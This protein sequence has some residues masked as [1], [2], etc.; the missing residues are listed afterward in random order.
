[1]KTSPLIC[2]ALLLAGCAS[3]YDMSKFL[4]GTQYVQKP[5]PSLSPDKVRG[6]TASPKPLNSYE[7]DLENAWSEGYFAI[8]DIQFCGPAMPE[9]DARRVA[10][11]HGADYF[12]FFCA[13]YGTATGSRMV[14]VGYTTPSVVTSSS[15]GN[16]YASSPYGGGVNVTGYGTSTSVV[17]GATIYGRENYTYQN[18][19][20]CIFLLVSPTRKAELIKKGYLTAD[21]ASKKNHWVK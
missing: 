17:G 2:L 8:G 5:V 3:N 6:V 21:S 7:K 16:A 15:Q 9:M 10:A 20:Q 12:V 11:K 4:K 14:P 1:M 13:P 18:Y 19:S